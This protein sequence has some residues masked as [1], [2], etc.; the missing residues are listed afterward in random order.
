MCYGR[1]LATR[2]KV[3]IGESVGVVAAQ[4]IGEPG[5]QLTMRTFH[6]GGVRQFTGEDITQGLPR[7]EQL[8]EVRRPKKVAILA[9]EEGTLVELREMD[10]K[11]KLII[12]KEHEDGTE[13]RVSYNIPASQNL[14]SGIEEGSHIK[15]GQILTEG[16][17]DPQQLLEVEGLEA[18]QHYLLDGIQEVYRSQGVSINDKHIETIL[19]KVAPVNRVRVMKEGDSAFVSGELV[20][21]DDLEKAVEE[22]RAQNAASLEESYNFIK[23][24]KII[25]V[26]GAAAPENGG[27]DFSAFG[28]GTLEAIL[29]PGSAAT[30]II[31]EDQSGE[32]R[33]I[34]GDTNFRRAMEGLELIGDFK[35]P[36]TGEVLISGGTRLAS[37]DLSV[38]TGFAP[39]PV[40]I[41]D[42]NLLEENK[43]KSW[44]A[45]DVADEA[46]ST[47][48]KSDAVLSD[49]VIQLL[50]KHN[51]KQI[52]LWKSP[53][54]INLTDAM[55]HVLIE[56]FFGK[57]V[58]QALNADGEVIED[59]PHVI[60]GS[61]ISGLIDGSIS[62][63]ECD[64]MILTRER[65][66]KLLL[67][68]RV[69]GKILLEP[70]SNEKGEI[71]AAG[72][73]EITSSLLDKIAAVATGTI[74]VRSKSSASEYK[75]L[76]QRVSF[77]R[78][79]SEEPQW[80]PVVHGVTKAALA[81]D[82][83]LSAA[84]FQQT[85]QVLAAAAVRGDVDTLAGLKENVIIGLLIPAGT[86]VERHR[87]VEITE[88][89]GEAQ[90]AEPAEPSF[91]E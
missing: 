71:V 81:T 65:V 20:W 42:M 13:E 30:E 56:H 2:K 55:H 27:Q 22:I 48:V 63:V 25:D 9:E 85:A 8:F 73:Q 17:I 1:D 70:V 23:D 57:A 16:Y 90:E 14:L 12:A 66:L 72:A 7:I 39:Q 24:Y 80:R 68:E 18:V 34:I 4:S 64:D 82:S 51:I 26:S 47:V 10:G 67:T 86:G 84:S 89:G 21:K 35:S 40:Y 32:V 53:E 61:V 43:D 49:E 76:M 69:L 29:Q 5:T 91:A 74:T 41:R 50:K 77:V 83:F 36:E 11:R 60:D 19:R 58:K 33:V 52:K 54:V 28:K 87:K 44:I 88:I 59:I 79:L 75:K 62:G 45:G 46:G 31:A 3:A 37:S 38:I 6:T 78:R 15:K